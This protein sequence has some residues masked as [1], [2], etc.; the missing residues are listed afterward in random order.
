MLFQLL[1]NKNECVAIYSNGELYF[2]D[3]PESMTA[4]WDYSV[5]LKGVDVQ[6]MSIYA[7][8]KTLEQVCPPHLKADLDR[9]SQKLKAFL[10]S[11]QEAKLSFKENCFY[12]LVP[13][14]FLKEYCEIKNRICEH[15]QQTHPAPKE[16]QFFKEF[17]ELN[18]DISTK[19]LNID[20]AWI[21]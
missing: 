16:Y 17:T 21:A 4:T 19:N 11:F 20:R 15:V 14:R 6:Y 5:S 10:T 3:I 18:G 9:V 13:H 12:D 8:G 7:E 2:D 1:D